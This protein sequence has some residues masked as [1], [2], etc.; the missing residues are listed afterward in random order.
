MSVPVEFSTG[1]TLALSYEGL[2]LPMS[3]LCSLSDKIRSSYN[4]DQ[5]IVARNIRGR[6]A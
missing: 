4:Y 6:C 3:S 5:K 2:T 1:I